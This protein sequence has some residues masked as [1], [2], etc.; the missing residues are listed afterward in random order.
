MENDL[1]L[2]FYVLKWVLIDIA[3]ELFSL[4]QSSWNNDDDDGTFEK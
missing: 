3:T 4:I 1:P 2:G